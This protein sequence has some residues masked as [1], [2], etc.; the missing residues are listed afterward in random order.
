MSLATYYLDYGRHV[1]RL[2]RRRRCRVYTPMNNTASQDNH[3]KINSWVS[4]AFL[5]V[6]EY[7]ALL[8]A[9][10]AAGAPLIVIPSLT[11]FISMLNVKVD[12]IEFAQL[13]ICSPN[14]S[15]LLFR[16]WTINYQMIVL[17]CVMTLNAYRT[18]EI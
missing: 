14:I 8:G 3:E 1:A 17:L 18:L 13:Y 10:W 7:G 5:H 6:F 15:S 4:F 12:F 16:T 2:R 9:L 11:F